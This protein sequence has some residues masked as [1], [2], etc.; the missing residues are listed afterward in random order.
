MIK[1]NQ[2]SWLKTYI[3]VNNDLRKAEG[4]DFENDLSKMMNNVVFG[5]TME[6]F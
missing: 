1:F 5:K 3:D 2:K 6:T 4:N